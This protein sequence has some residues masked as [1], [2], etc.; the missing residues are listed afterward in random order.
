MTVSSRKGEE[1]SSGLLQVVV[2][3]E[4]RGTKWLL[5][6]GFCWLG[7]LLRRLLL[8]LL[9][10]L[11]TTTTSTRRFSH[12][13]L[14]TR[15]RTTAAVGRFSWLQP[16]LCVHRYRS[17]PSNDVVN[18]SCSDD[19]N[20]SEIPG[21]DAHPHHSD[22]HC[23][24]QQE[25]ETVKETFEEGCSRR[26]FVTLTGSSVFAGVTSLLT[27]SSFPDHA[28][29]A[30]LLPSVTQSSPSLSSSSSSPVNI[31]GI[32]YSSVRKYK[33]ITLAS[34]GLQVLLVNDKRAASASCALTVH[35][36][37]Q[38]YDPNDLPGLAHLMEHMILS[39]SSSTWKVYNPNRD[40][41]DWLEDCD[42]AS[43][44]FTAN[45]KVCFHFMC[46]RSYLPEA[47]ERF[48]SLFVQENVESI[49]RDGEILKREVKRVN[50]ELDFDNSIA[51]EEYIT[52]Q[53]VNLEH[54]YSSFS[55]GSTETLQTL[56]QHRG[57]DVGER[58]IEFFER[59][60]LPRQAVLVVIGPQDVGTLERYVQPF[61]WTLSKQQR[62]VNSN[63]KPPSDYFPG[64]FLHGN[65]PKQVVLYRKSDE[66]SV[67]TEKLTLQWVLEVD[68]RD[69]ANGKR[70]NTAPQIAFVLS[71]ILGR[72]GPGSLYSFL[73]R[74]GWIP[75]GSTSV[76]R[77]S[78]PVEVSGF[79]ILKMEISLTTDG[80]L[81]RSNVVA[82]VYECIETLR[83]GFAFVLQREIVAQYASVAKLF[84]YY[85]APRPPDAIEL[86]FDAQV[87]GLEAVGSG[88]W[89][90]FPSAEEQSG[91]GLNPI[92]RAVSA[93]LSMMSD[94]DNAVIITTAG[95]KSI[96]QSNLGIRSESIPSRDS[97]R[98]IKEP[99]S[100]G[101]FYFEDMLQLKA[102]VEQ[103]VL[104]KLVDAE[105]LN[106][107][108][109][110]SLVPT[111]LRPPRVMLC[112]SM[113]PTSNAD[114]AL[115][116]SGLE[117][118]SPLG[119]KWTLMQLYPGQQGLPL[120]RAPPEPNCRCYF[121]VQLLSTRP[122]RADVRQAARAELWKL[123]FE[124][125][126]TDLAEL[127]A[128]GGLFYDVSFNKFGL[129]LC[130]LGISQTISSYT[131]RLTRRLARHHEDL[132]NGPETIRRSIR[133]SAVQNVARAPNVSPGR[134]GRIV[135]N[136][137]SSTA[138]E[139]AS[140]G[141]AFLRSCTGAVCFS[142]GD[143][144]MSE[145]MQLMEELERIF[146]LA[147]PNRQSQQ[148][149]AVP[150]F[151]ELLYKPVWKPRFASACAISGV[152]LISDACG[153]I[154]R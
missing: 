31:P 54:P 132:L 107:P 47:L 32:P 59:Y 85:L 152:S 27:A 26:D 88:K 29:A 142:E 115:L 66:F 151:H 6:S 128:P 86:A 21:C 71:Q 20:K 117:M 57:I 1:F 78:I 116:W 111:S 150:S 97:A 61:A 35:A 144:T 55:R 87:Y 49:C 101:L 119:S 135:S 122:A 76:P 69:L 44:A 140:E 60:Y 14:P 28:Q 62:R 38:F 51:Q 110:N 112:T 136:L 17:A 50:A 125:A 94:P 3:V 124:K 146:G 143:L 53:F 109:F 65:R 58:L 36:A 95:E 7:F 147:T 123:T 40:F 108:I 33:T 131:R 64:Q 75:G 70:I 113:D 8:L 102:R 42:G 73:T 68:Y 106:R 90:R 81:N 121:V 126:V 133:S 13:L 137:K 114:A 89:Y 41:E 139:V 24:R 74:R 103:L 67:D 141:I 37:G 12:A 120:P 56:P 100:E 118:Q 45:Q 77:I 149:S 130:F 154:P 129:R 10:L 9:L 153:R 48:A 11:A 5:P 105:E 46:P 92:R 52:K 104:T 72:R 148:S 15:T 22:C 39:Y 30:A 96:S 138:Y 2:D 93:T 79:Q 83:S 63:L 98:W 145:T 91:L 99:V 134:K 23:T 43:N 84:G 80:F 18:T 4:R 16:F 19:D 82:A 127:G 25:Q 34:N